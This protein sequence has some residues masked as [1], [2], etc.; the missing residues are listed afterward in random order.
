[1]VVSGEEAGE[2]LQTLGK[3]NVGLTPEKI[4]ELVAEVDVDGDGELE[5]SEFVEY[6]LGQD[7]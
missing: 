2:L 1:M 3:T 4:K 7:G 6:I 5:L